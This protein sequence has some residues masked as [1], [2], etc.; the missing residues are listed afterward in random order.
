[1][2]KVNRKALDSASHSC[3][4]G[5]LGEV[6]RMILNNK[7]AEGRLSS[8]LNLINRLKTESPRKSAMSLFIKPLVLP[9]EEEKTIKEVKQE[10][11]FNPFESK[12]LV[13]PEIPSSSPTLDNLIPN[14]Q[15][16]VKLNLAHDK[17]LSIL[18]SAMEELELRLS[19]VKAEK[20]PSVITA[21][22]KVVEGIRRER[23]E[24][25]KNNKDREVHYHFYTPEQKKVSQ[26]DII[27]VTTEARA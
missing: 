11:L 3:Y 12:K 8:P 26:Y 18:N 24:A 9:R 14:N 10:I 1:M 7:E 23:L 2:K 19:E 6:S 4:D 13:L 20:L 17:A 5:L 15:E 16:Q 22:S 27:D 25:S 21:T